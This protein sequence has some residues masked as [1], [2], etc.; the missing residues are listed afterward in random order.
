MTIRFGILTI[1]DRSSR[2]ERED[3]SG[4]A[5]ARLIQAEGWSV[6]KQGVLPDEESAIRELLITWADSSELDVIPTTG[7]TA[8]PRDVT[9]KMAAVLDREAPGLAVPCVPVH[10]RRMP[11][12]PGLSQGSEN[13]QSSSIFPAAQKER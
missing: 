11:C 3:A 6:T 9:L 2:G 8:S 1:S 5:L 13:G 12:Y 4:P 10:G 7:G